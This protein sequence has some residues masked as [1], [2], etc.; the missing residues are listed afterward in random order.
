MNSLKVE[1]FLKKIHI[2]YHPTYSRDIPLGS[3]DGTPPKFMS[4]SMFSSKPFMIL[5]WFSPSLPDNNTELP[6]NLST[7]NIWQNGDEFDPKDQ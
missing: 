7:P 4:T 6:P 1:F 3:G 2:Y 5:S